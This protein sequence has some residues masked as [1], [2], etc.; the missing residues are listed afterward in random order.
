MRVS[1]PA[2]VMM[3]VVVVCERIGDLRDGWGR[4]QYFSPFPSLGKKKKIKNDGGGKGGKK[5]WTG[6]NHGCGHSHSSAT[7]RAL[8]VVVVLVGW[9]GLGWWR[10]E[11][12]SVNA[13][14][15]RR[16]SHYEDDGCTAEGEEA[17]GSSRTATETRCS[18]GLQ[19]VKVPEYLG[20]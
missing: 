19:R 4:T 8:V 3:V 9:A 12:R 20:T 1:V 18:T 2:W 5:V 13:E 16:S 6:Y 11:G 17:K 14:Q 10:L 7:A 15:W